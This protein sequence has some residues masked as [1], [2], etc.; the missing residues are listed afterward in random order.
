MPWL[1][2]MAALTT[3]I[4]LGLRFSEG[5]AFLELAARAEPGWLLVGAVLQAGTYVT[6]GSIWFV[7]SATATSRLQ[8]RTTTRISLAKLF[9][10]QALPS[11]GLSGSMI[12]ASALR[13]HGVPTRTVAAAIGLECA[14][15]HSAHAAALGAALALGIARGQVNPLVIVGAALFVLVSISLAIG[16]V[17]VAGGAWRPWPWVR[18]ITPISRLLK[19][20]KDANR[21]LV[22]SPRLLALTFG[23]QLLIIALDTGTMLAVIRSLGATVPTAGVFLSF[24]TSSLLR[25]VGVVPGGLGTFDASSVLTLRMTGATLPVALSATLL[26]RGLSY[27]L[28]LLPGLWYARRLTQRQ[29]V[30]LRTSQSGEHLS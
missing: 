9:V 3:V 22:R 7:I 11:A 15:F 6:E 23:L 25:T 10:D 5:R 16:I 18:R 14:G 28:P 24:M 19:F 8:F 27:W 13:A 4:T 21:R 2:G 12:T 29:D 30:E 1:V 17:V 26:F 20:L